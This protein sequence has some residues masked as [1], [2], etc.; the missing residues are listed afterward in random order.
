MKNLEKERET[1]KQIKMKIVFQPIDPQ[2]VL[3]VFL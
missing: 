3:N 2:V 1:E